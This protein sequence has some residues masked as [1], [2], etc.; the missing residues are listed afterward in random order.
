[1]DEGLCNQRTILEDP[2]IIGY[3]IKINHL[4]RK[5]THLVTESY[6]YIYLR[7]IFPNV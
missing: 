4:F 7:I 5:T 1:M 2:S 3:E 6:D